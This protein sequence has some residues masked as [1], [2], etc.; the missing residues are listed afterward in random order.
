M[1]PI[2]VKRFYGEKK[3]LKQ[4]QYKSSVRLV[5]ETLKKDIFKA[6]RYP[7]RDQRR[8]TLRVP[9]LKEDRLFFGRRGIEELLA[10]DPQHDSSW[11]ERI[12]SERGDVNYVL[13]PEVKVHVRKV[14]CEKDMKIGPD[15]RVEQTRKEHGYQLVV[16]LV[17][18]RRPG[19]P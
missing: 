11:H 12:V 9:I 7:V 16:K 5:V 15:G 17:R 3:P 19:G 10:T 4:L 6:L 13:P 2:S 8:K 18:Y 14:R 1:K